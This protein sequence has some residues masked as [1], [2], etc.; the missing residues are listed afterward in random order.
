MVSV[1]LLCCGATRNPYRLMLLIRIV[2][3]AVFIAS[4]VMKTADWPGARRAAAE[5]G[6]PPSMARPVTAVLVGAELVISLCLLDPVTAPAGGW[7]AFVVLAGLTGVV[8]VNLARGRR[9]ACHCFGR[10][11]TGAIGWHTVGR[12][13][14]LAMGA[15]AV[16]LAGQDAQILAASGL[17]ALALWAG[18]PAWRRWSHRRGITAASFSL[19]DQDGTRRSLDSM[20]DPVRPLLLVFTQ[21]TCG[22]CHLVLPQ[23]AGWKAEGLIQVAVVSGGPQDDVIAGEIVSRSAVLRDVEHQVFA[24]FGITSTPAAVLIDGRRRLLA[25]PAFGG[26]DIEGLV[27]R[28]AATASQRR[29]SRRRFM[30]R[31]G[32]FAALPFASAALAACGSSPASDTRSAAAAAKQQV[33]V[34]GAWLCDQRYA[35]CTG[36][37]CVPSKADPKVAVCRCEVLDGYSAGYLP[38]TKRRPSGSTVVST[39]STQNLSSALAVMT[40]PSDAPWANC[41]DVTCHVDAAHPDKA[42][43]NCPIVENGPSFTFVTDC[44][45][46]TCTQVVWSGAAPPG[47]TQYTPAMKKVGKKV[48]FPRNCPTS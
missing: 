24:A 9:P 35:L 26:A 16:G 34:D 6:V 45:T 43:C 5:L 20:L 11:S 29:W 2:L 14:L 47:V 3:A 19:P 4:G 46:A 25:A 12:N 8:A 30:V 13:L 48:T 31:V 44:N 42:I 37:A 40:C 41:L 18:P 7:G 1:R 23:V 28:P 36:A 22:A 10:F 15:V 39:F 33:E 21:P 32:P 17:C 27:T 38:C